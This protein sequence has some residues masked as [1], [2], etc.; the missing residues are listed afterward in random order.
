MKF[1]VTETQLA[2]IF[3]KAQEIHEASFELGEEYTVTVCS[4][5]LTLHHSSYK[6]DHMVSA[7]AACA[8]ILGENHPENGIPYVIYLM[9]S[10][11]WNDIQLWAME[12]LGI[13]PK[14]IENDP[15][16]LS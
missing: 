7:I 15:L 8:D 6:K 2:Q 12:V 4:T 14:E 16:S 3:L 13:K 9:N 10:M 11:A 1:N 5:E